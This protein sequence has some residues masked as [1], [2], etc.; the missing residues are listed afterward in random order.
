MAVKPENTFITGV[1]KHLPSVKSL[2]REK[3]NNPYRGGTADWWYSAARSDLWIEYK[4]LPRLPQRGDM[5]PERYGLTEL[6]L[7]WLRGRHEEGRN[8][9]V[10]VGTPKGGVIMRDLEWEI[11]QSPAAFVQQIVD[12]KSLADWIAQQVLE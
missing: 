9:A 7:T 3:M 12:R 10:I 2:Y 5:T 1:H 6:Q 4:F 11:P 8:V